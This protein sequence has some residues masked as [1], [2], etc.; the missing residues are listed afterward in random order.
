MKPA[1]EDVEAEESAV[2]TG[3][4]EIV[5]DDARLLL[6]VDRY[7]P[8]AAKSSEPAGE[9]QLA[10]FASGEDG[11]RPLEA[12]VLPELAPIPEPPLYT[13]RRLSYSALS[14][15]ELCSY[16]FYAERI[17]GM[18]PVRRPSEVVGEPGLAATEIGDAVHFLLERVDLAAPAVPAE[19]E[20]LVR[21]R[22]PDVS[23]E[24]LERIGTFVAGYCD[25]GLA[26]RVAA[27][28]RAAPE[29]P[30]AVEHDG[31]LLHGRIDVFHLADERALV[32]DYKTNALGEAVPAEIVEAEY[33]IQRLVYALAC[34]RA[35]AEE[36]EVVYQFLE[37]PDDLV[38]RTYSRADLTAL[39]DELSVAIARIQEGEFR[40]TPS[41]FACSECPALVVVC[42][43]PRLRSAATASAAAVAL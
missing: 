14:L 21:S 11:S 13:A 31:V 28:T 36:V 34:F 24:E 1:R 17:A 3:D 4:V 25:S 16:R 19:A 32:V 37:R 30:F 29:R 35:G 38:A 15:Y 41:D 10:L 7:V 43:G 39:E 8:A 42:A 5:R 33:R 40:P 22:Y 18:R 27:L 2:G 9:P 20:D 6:R 12:P 23:A 26:R